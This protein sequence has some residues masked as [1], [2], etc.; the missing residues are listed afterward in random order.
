MAKN[1]TNVDILT[2]TFN[3]W[4]LRT[5]EVIDVLNNEVLTA[6]S[7]Q[8]VTGSVTS[9][10]NAL[11]YGSFTA[12]T[13]AGNTIA[14]NS[15]FIA[16]SSAIL[17]GKTLKF[18]AN[19]SAGTAGQTLTTDGSSIY[20]STAPGSGTVTQIANGAGIYFSDGNNGSTIIGVGK[21]NLR[22]NTGI[23]VDTGGISVNSNYIATLNSANAALLL[24]RAWTNPGQIGLTIANTGAFTTLTVSDTISANTT[25]GYKLTGDSNFIANSSVIRTAGYV[26]ATTPNSG[27]TGGVRIRSTGTG[28]A[29]VAYLQITNSDNTDEFGNFLFHSNGQFIWSG[30]ARIS[31]DINTANL[32]FDGVISSPNLSI[33]ANGTI[34]AKEIL[35]P[36]SSYV[37]LTDFSQSKSTNGYVQLPNGLIIQWGQFRRTVSSPT[38][39]NLIFNTDFSNSAYSIATTSYYP[40]VSYNAWHVVRTGDG[41]G[42]YAPMAQITDD[43]QSGSH[44]G[45]D[46]VAIGPA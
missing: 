29:S 4:I 37:K 16:N 35:I 14:I 33:G 6:N 15:D 32:T 10:R 22:A 30:D 41:T 25:A 43:T 1:V 2:D 9:S 18:I 31:G 20:W 36:S 28:A 7:T 42:T 5:N 24:G 46:W 27:T 3:T 17:I 45:F 13:L 40:A 39:L 19:N 26:D 34:S 21:I 11:L 38:A 23:I 8:G 12:N 44:Y